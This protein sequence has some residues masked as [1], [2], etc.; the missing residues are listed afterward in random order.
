MGG[1]KLLPILLALAWA[2]VPSAAQ[3]DIKLQGDE[4]QRFLR[5]KG[6]SHLGKDVAWSVPAKALSEPRSTRGGWCLFAVKGVGLL[7]EEGSSDLAEVRRRGGSALA[8]GTVQ[9]VPEKERRPGDPSH[10]LVVRT[11]SRRK[12]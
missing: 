1:M 5:T 4:L 9:A 2:A 10:V 7:I 3:S 11:L 6:A 12:G 8:R